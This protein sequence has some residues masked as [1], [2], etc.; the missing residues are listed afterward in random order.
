M[1]SIKGKEDVCTIRWIVA[2]LAHSR[3]LPT[4]HWFLYVFS[5]IGSGV[6]SAK[7]KGFLLPSWFV[8]FY[9]VAIAGDL[10]CVLYNRAR[11]VA[12]DR[13]ADGGHL[14]TPSGS[15][16]VCVYAVHN[17]TS[18]LSL[19]SILPALAAHRHTHTHYSCPHRS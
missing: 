14:V 18:F 6:N 8:G 10:S 2:S 13:S 16:V 7:R 12:A 11:P 5:C 4:S 15:H 9:G 17:A 3:S 19:P 1:S